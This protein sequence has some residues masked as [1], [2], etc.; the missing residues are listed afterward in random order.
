MKEAS[1]LL[2]SSI[3]TVEKDRI[4]L[5]EDELPTDDLDATEIDMANAEIQAME[6]EAS[7]QVVQADRLRR[8]D[9]DEF[10]RAKELLVS[11]V[12][13]QQE[14]KKKKNISQSFSLSHSP[15]SLSYARSHLSK[16]RRHCLLGTRVL[17]IWE[18]IKV[19]SNACLGIH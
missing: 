5:E 14:G 16:S 12:R 3:L 8:M 15:P 6:V 18:Q 2:Q 7:Q 1:R 4:D 13:R 19:F 10:E 11:E 17:R 9:Y